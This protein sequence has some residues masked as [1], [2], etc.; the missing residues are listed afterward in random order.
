MQFHLI[1]TPRGEPPRDDVWTAEKPEVGS[2]PLESRRA[3]V[4]HL[5]TVTPRREMSGSASGRA[6]EA[7]TT[8]AST[9]AIELPARSYLVGSGPLATASE[10][11]LEVRDQSVNMW[12]P[13]DRAWFV[14]TE[15]DYAWTYLG[16]PARL[17][18][19]VLA[20]PR[21]EALAATVTDK[22]FYDSDLLN[23]AE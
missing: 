14:S 17:I 9:R 7:S 15:I 10:S 22:P 13:H 20:D 12:W 1:D 16:G 19:D 5:D 3:L 23:A 21:L 4:E 2:L 18:E 8:R 6:G 11:T